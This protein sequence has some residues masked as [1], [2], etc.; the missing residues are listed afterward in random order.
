MSNNDGASEWFLADNNGQETPDWAVVRQAPDYVPAETLSR[1]GG[2]ATD[3]SRGGPNN[4]SQHPKTRTQLSERGGYLTDREWDE[5]RPSGSRKY[6]TFPLQLKGVKFR[7]SSLTYENQYDSEWASSSDDN[8]ADPGVAAPRPGER[9]QPQQRAA[10]AISSPTSSNR[11]PQHNPQNT[12]GPS[13]GSQRPH[14]PRSPKKA[15][16]GE[17]RPSSSHRRQP[18][19]PGQSGGRVS[20]SGQI[21]GPIRPPSGRGQGGPGPRDNRANP[22]RTPI[23]RGHG[24]TGSASG[25]RKEERK[26]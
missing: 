26:T 19:T 9:L 22:E 7:P 17:S 12:P 4:R 15:S 14:R 6:D 18:G 8:A 10:N 23:A 11:D 2:S 24:G 13:V 1:V 21:P 3:A 5:R 25:K 20:S 16:S